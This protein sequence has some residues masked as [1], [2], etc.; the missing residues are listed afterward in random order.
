[1]FPGISLACVS[2]LEANFPGET[3]EKTLTREHI[4][5]NYQHPPGVVPVRIRA[6]RFLSTGTAYAAAD[7][8]AL[9]YG[10]TCVD[11][12]SPFPS[13]QSRPTVNRTRRQPEQ[14]RSDRGAYMSTFLIR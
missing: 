2:L 10:A 4:H 13:Y 8:A 11:V 1:M 9:L 6:R 5:G 7:R 12:D 3:K 14:A